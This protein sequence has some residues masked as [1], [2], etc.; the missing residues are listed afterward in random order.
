MSDGLKHEVFETQE[1]IDAEL[2]ELTTAFADLDRLEVLLRE[3]GLSLEKHAAF[4][5]S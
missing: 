3:Y 1:L 4:L 2:A 5:Y